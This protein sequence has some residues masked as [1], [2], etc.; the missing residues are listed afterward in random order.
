MKGQKSEYYLGKYIT[1]TIQ[2]VF[3]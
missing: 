1:N 2:M 3:V